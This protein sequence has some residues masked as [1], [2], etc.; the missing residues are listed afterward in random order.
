MLNEFGMYLSVG[1]WTAIWEGGG[2]EF[3]QMIR[4]RKERV[5][6][7]RERGGRWRRDS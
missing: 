3:I 1:H 6:E 5:R 2:G 4:S 7:E